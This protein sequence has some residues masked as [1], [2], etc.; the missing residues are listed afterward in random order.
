MGRAVAAAGERGGGGDAYHPGIAEGTGAAGEEET[1]G[2][3]ASEELTFLFFF[4]A[5]GN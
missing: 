4:I 1:V 3:A 2:G 5:N